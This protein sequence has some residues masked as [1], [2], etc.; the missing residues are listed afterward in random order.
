MKTLEN[1]KDWFFE[2][3]KEKYRSDL[4][5]NTLIALKDEE[6]NNLFKSLQKSI[7]NYRELNNKLKSSDNEAELKNL[8]NYRTKLHDT[9]RASIRQYPDV[10]YL[11]SSA[12][13]NEPLGLQVCRLGFEDLA[14]EIL[15]TNKLTAFQ[16]NPAGEN[17]A[18]IALGNG[19][20]K[21]ALKTFDYPESLDHICRYD[22]SFQK[23]Y[24]IENSNYPFQT[25]KFDNIGFTAVK[26]KGA[27]V[28]YT[29]EQKADYDKVIVKCL[30]NKNIRTYTSSNHGGIGILMMQYHNAFDED[31]LLKALDY[32]EICTQR[33]PNDGN[34]VG[35]YCA[36]L[37]N[38]KLTLKAL[39]VKETHTQTNLDKKN[40]GMLAAING[41]EEA[42]LKALDNHEASLQQDNNGFNIGMW[43]AYYCL[44]KATMKALDNHEASIQQ[45]K[46]G[47]NIGMFALKSGLINCVFKS[48]ENKVATAQQNYEKLTIGHKAVDKCKYSTSN[49]F[50]K[51]DL[52]EVINITLDNEEAR[53]VQ[54]DFGNTIGMYA[55][56]KIYPN[57]E[58]SKLIQKAASFPDSC[59]LKNKDK[60]D[61]FTIAK[62]RNFDLG[63]A[64]LLDIQR[65][66]LDEIID[67]FGLDLS[68]SNESEM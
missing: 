58:S 63:E 3:R 61:I 36:K 38:E 59:Y 53:K 27:R 65:D 42:T 40:I 41:L 10:L 14:L 47:E 7:L 49:N 25:G 54:S 55:A 23:E 12:T 46:F 43:S 17:M 13:F 35:M 8:D 1:I 57:E 28:N 31:M 21:V 29:D 24:M 34:T 51:E 67:T 68:D 4:Y 15:E 52:F 45:D 6:L 44:E 19:L 9:I 39:D 16:Q 18:M 32:D 37:K 50:S 30:E 56:I 33:N 48:L 5:V 26:A 62:E 20:P 22:H 64:S 2:H 66:E 60:K 11:K